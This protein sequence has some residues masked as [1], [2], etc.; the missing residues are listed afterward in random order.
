M[1]L[2]RDVRRTEKNKRNMRRTLDVRTHRASARTR[3]V[4]TSALKKVAA[5]AIRVFQQSLV[6]ISC[7]HH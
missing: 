1:I 4:L 3:R 2:H 6:Q 5:T 7:A